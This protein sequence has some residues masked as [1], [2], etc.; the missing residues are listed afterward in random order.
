MHILVTKMERHRS[1]GWTSQWIRKWMHSKGCGQW[2]D[3]CVETS[4]EWYPSGTILFNILMLTWERGQWD[5]VHSHQV[6]GWQV[7]WCDWYSREKEFHPER[8]G[9]S[10]VCAVLMYFNKAKCEVL[11]LDWGNPKH[12]HR[13]G[14]E[15][16]ETSPVEKDLGCWWMKNWTWSNCILGC[17]KRRRTSRLRAVIL[18]LYCTFVWPPP[19]VLHPFVSFPA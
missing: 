2:S 16:V 7:Q 19:G 6:W 11:C 3:G 14:D 17:I 15:W 5:W 4:D 18:H 13:L 9:Q 10:C 1:D 8:P 12:G